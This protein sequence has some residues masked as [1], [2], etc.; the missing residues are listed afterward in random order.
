ME[1]WLVVFTSV[2]RDRREVGD[3]LKLIQLL[4]TLYT[5]LLTGRLIV[6]I[7]EM[8]KDKVLKGKVWKRNIK[9]NNER[10]TIINKWKEE[11]IKKVLKNA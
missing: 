8:M 7:T 3:F 11:M 5:L 6:G 1:D 2:P 4:K 9:V 10:E